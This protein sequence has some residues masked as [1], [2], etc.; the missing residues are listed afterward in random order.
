MQNTTLNDYIADIQSA[1][2]VDL[3]SYRKSLESALLAPTNSEINEQTRALIIDLIE[4][5]N[6]ELCIR[7]LIRI[8]RGDLG[9]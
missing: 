1:E 3:L 2:T 7:E 9:E 8:V 6:Q 5:I 4:H